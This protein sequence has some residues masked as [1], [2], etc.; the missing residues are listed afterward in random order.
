MI[1]QRF[2]N[3]LNQYELVSTIFYHAD[4]ERSSLLLHETSAKSLVAEATSHSEKTRALYEVQALEFA[5]ANAAV[6]EKA[7]E[8]ATWLEQHG[9]VL[10]ALRSDSI[11]EI[12]SLIHI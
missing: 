5:Q 8:A 12:L 9:R 10:D 11:S 1:W 3:V 6:T 2:F 4:Q 7:Q